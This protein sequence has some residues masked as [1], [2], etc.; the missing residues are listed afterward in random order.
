[1]A[2]AGHAD[3]R[4]D[5]VFLNMVTGPTFPGYGNI[6]KQCRRAW[7]FWVSRI[8]YK[9]PCVDYDHIRDDPTLKEFMVVGRWETNDAGTRYFQHGASAGVRLRE[10]DGQLQV[11]GLVMRSPADG[12]ELMRHLK[13][14]CLYIPGVM[15]CKLYIEV[16]PF[17]KTLIDILTDHDFVRHP[18]SRLH[19]VV[20]IIA[21]LD[22]VFPLGSS[23]ISS[24]LYKAPK[25]SSRTS[26][27]TT[28]PKFSF[29]EL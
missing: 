19:N 3:T 8:D 1:M 29:V 11:V 9:P 27:S 23:K 13:K 5:A 16:M 21:P 20:G 22:Y 24:A 26:K 14:E 15:S 18:D 4:D 10:S 25:P 2:S 28:T 17:H 7:D 6:L 12:R